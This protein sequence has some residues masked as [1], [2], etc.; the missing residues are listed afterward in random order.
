MFKPGAGCWGGRLGANGLGGPVAPA[1]SR[2][3]ADGDGGGRTMLV[4]E[5]ESF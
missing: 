2:A 5:C 3:D 4:D 1:E